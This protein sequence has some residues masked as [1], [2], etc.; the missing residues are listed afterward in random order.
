MVK[1]YHPPGRPV[2]E[3]DVPVV[4]CRECGASIQVEDPGELGQRVVCPLCGVR[5]ELVNLEPPELDW[6]FEQSFWDEVWT[7]ERQEMEEV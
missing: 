1:A 6:V 3:V 2:E 5:F 7:V 4:S